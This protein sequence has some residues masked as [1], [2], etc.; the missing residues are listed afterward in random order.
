[1]ISAVNNICKIIDSFDYHKSIVQHWDKLLV[2][3][4]PSITKE[5]Q[6]E[7]KINNLEDKIDGIE[8]I[9]SNMKNILTQLTPKT[10]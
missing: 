9:L 4:N 3:L 7:E 8:N 2:I 6:E 10:M 1:M 5:K